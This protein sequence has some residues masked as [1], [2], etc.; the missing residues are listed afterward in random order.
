ML[1]RFAIGPMWQI[2]ASTRS[3]RGTVHAGSIV[4]L[5]F[6]HAI[7]HRNVVQGVLSYAI[8]SGNM[9]AVQAHLYP[10]MCSANRSTQV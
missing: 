5:N 8:P 10:D 4:A 7:V 1:K 6:A 3:K 9:R 2:A